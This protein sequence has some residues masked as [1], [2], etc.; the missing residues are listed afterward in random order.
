[1]WKVPS[2]FSEYLVSEDATIIRVSTGEVIIHDGKN[3]SLK[4]DD[5]T[6]KNRSIKK[7]LA[8]TFEHPAQL[9][10]ATSVIDT[11]IKKSFAN[12][13][14]AAKWLVETKQA[15]TSGRLAA[16]HTIRTNIKNGIN[17]P[18]LY[19]FIYGYAWKVEEGG[20]QDGFSMGS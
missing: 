13:A 20:Q 14:E 9:V 7:L 12:I 3:A 15:I 4:S 10:V 16:Y 18:E 19:P 8:E 2:N 11:D 17:Q 6:W 1:M 5:G